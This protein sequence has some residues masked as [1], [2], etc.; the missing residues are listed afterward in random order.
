VFCMVSNVMAI[1]TPIPLAPGSLQPAQVKAG[2]GLMQMLGMMVLPV[3]GLPGVGPYGLGGLLDQLNVVK[4]VP[5][6][7]P[8]SVVVFALMVL[9]Q[10]WEIRLEGDWLTD[11]E[12]KILEIVTSRAE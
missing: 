3:G 1:L 12:Q 8:L 10:S 6:A 5:L 11:R 4:G 7:L 9:V 2:P